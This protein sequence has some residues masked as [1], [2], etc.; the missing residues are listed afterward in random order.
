MEK[1]SM[2]D[3]ALIGVRAIYLKGKLIYKDGEDEGPKKESEPVDLKK[4]KH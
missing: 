4:E 1:A 2:K 3:S